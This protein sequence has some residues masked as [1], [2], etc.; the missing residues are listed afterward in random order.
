MQNM[1]AGFVSCEPCPFD[2]HATKRTGIDFTF[3]RTAPRATPVLKLG[4]F[5]RGL[6]DEVFDDILFAQPVAA[7]HGIVEVII[8]TIFLALHARC[9]AFGGNGVATHWINLRYQ[10]DLQRRI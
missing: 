2:L 5:D 7:T 1:E 8:V 6:L 9:T 4:Q 3:R 10:C